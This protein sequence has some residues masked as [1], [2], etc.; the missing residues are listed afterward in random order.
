MPS[1]KDNTSQPEHIA[2]RETPA[3]RWWPVAFYSV[4]VFLWFITGVVAGAWD[5]LWL[6]VLP[7]PALA[8]YL[9]RIRRRGE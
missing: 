2:R 9:W 5:L 1:P 7:L 6:V 4:N 8:L 3:G